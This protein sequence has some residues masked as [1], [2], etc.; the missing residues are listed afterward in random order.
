[1]NYTGDT[2]YNKNQISKTRGCEKRLLKS[3]HLGQ[4]S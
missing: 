3:G 1:M 4:K 2:G